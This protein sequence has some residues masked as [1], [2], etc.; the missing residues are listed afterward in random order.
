MSQRIKPVMSEELELTEQVPKELD[1]LYWGHHGESLAALRVA[2]GGIEIGFKNGSDGT[3]S[4]GEI[5][6]SVKF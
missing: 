5:D 4:L 6:T 2:G 1:A 3:I